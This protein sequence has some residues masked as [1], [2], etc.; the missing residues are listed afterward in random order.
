MWHNS[1]KVKAHQAINLFITNVLKAHFVIVF[2]AVAAV[3]AA[4]KKLSRVTSQSRPRSRN[5]SQTVLTNN[6]STD[7]CSAQT[8]ERPAC[9]SVIAKSSIAVSVS[10]NCDA[11][12]VETVHNNTSDVRSASLVSPSSSRSSGIL[13]SSVHKLRPSSKRPATSVIMPSVSRFPPSPAVTPITCPPLVST[14]SC[15]ASL[16]FHSNSSSVFSVGAPSSNLTHTCLTW[17]NT[18]ALAAPMITGK[19]TSS[20]SAAAKTWNLPILSVDKALV[21]SS[22]HSLTALSNASHGSLGCTSGLLQTL[23]GVTRCSVTQPYC[24]VFGPDPVQSSLGTIDGPCSRKKLTQRVDRLV[25]VSQALPLFEK[26]TQRQQH[27]LDI[28]N[29]HVCHLPSAARKLPVFPSL[30]A[31][32]VHKSLFKSSLRRSSSL[33]CLL[34]DGA[35][36]N[37]TET[38]GNE[39]A[40]FNDTAEDR[41]QK[42]NSSTG[43]ATG[44]PHYRLIV[45]PT[46]EK[47][48]QVDMCM[49]C[50]Q[51]GCRGLGLAAA[52]TAD[53]GIQVDIEVETTCGLSQYEN[54]PIGCC[55]QCRQPVATAIAATSPHGSLRPVVA[56]GVTS[57]PFADSGPSDLS[58]RWTGE[59][60][61]VSA[62]PRRNSTASVSTTT[63]LVDGAAASTNASVFLPVSCAFSSN[64][65]SSVSTTR[66]CFRNR[67]REPLAS[68]Q[69]ASEIDQNSIECDVV[70]DKCHSAVSS[71]K[72]FIVGSSIAT[73]EHRRGRADD[74]RIHRLIELPTSKTGSFDS[75]QNVARE[76]VVSKKFQTVL[77]TECDRYKGQTENWSSDVSAEQ[78]CVADSDHDVIVID[79][80]AESSKKYSYQ[81]RR[82]PTAGR[83]GRRRKLDRITKLRMGRVTSAT[84]RQTSDKLG[85]DCDDNDGG[86]SA[87]NSSYDDGIALTSLGDDDDASELY[88]DRT[89]V[90]WFVDMLLDHL[91]WNEC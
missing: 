77:E 61:G 5:V 29:Q 91:P 13:H 82:S 40:G 79:G 90:S 57:N 64:D 37:Q 6:Q 16:V 70:S 74:F 85:D 46:A 15:P 36:Y 44:Y 17:S 45:A 60:A 78:M 49:G 76:S 26:V 42:K 4:A 88:P 2:V 7:R 24:A 48:I 86:Q 27:N 84:N 58:S 89:P 19:S 83:R 75:L 73:S 1:C 67:E 12:N 28:E 34:I 18:A 33:P 66:R 87:V 63:C 72:N 55:M 62:E 53:I 71:A 68:L 39:F 32:N 65:S 80:D 59:E 11:T 14:L 43:G 25:N 54:K 35:S 56:S 50:E 10:V 23:S 8:P 22:T 31:D 38:S 51:T 52:D 69:D 41:F 3:D 47:A 81:G 20:S 9:A 30:A 21:S